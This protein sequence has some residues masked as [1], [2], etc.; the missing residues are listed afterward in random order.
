MG[1][2]KFVLFKTSTKLWAK[3]AKVSKNLHDFGKFQ[4]NKNYFEL[5]GSIIF[6]RASSEFQ[7]AGRPGETG[8][9]CQL[10]TMT[11]DNWKRKK[12]TFE[13]FAIVWH[14]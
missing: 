7:A 3:I 1:C 11:M 9:L 6:F 13:M 14:L 4:A 10:S 2:K 8:A 12:K 5:S